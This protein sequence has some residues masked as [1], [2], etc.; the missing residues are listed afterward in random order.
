MPKREKKPAILVSLPPEELVK[1]PTLSQE[2]IQSALETG[3]EERKAAEGRPS[4]FS[5]TA[6]LQTYSEAEAVPRLLAIRIMPWETDGPPL[7]SGLAQKK[8]HTYGRKHQQSTGHVVEYTTIGAECT[9]CRFKA[10]GKV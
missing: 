9:V 7:I 2:E 1:V 6:S 3:S 10:F 5:V 4:L 8:L